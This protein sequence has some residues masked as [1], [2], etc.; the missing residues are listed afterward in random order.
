MSLQKTWLKPSH[1]YGVFMNFLRLEQF[2]CQWLD[3]N[4]ENIKMSSFVFVDDQ[5]L[6]RLGND[7]KITIF[8]FQLTMASIYRNS[9]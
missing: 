2:G 9:V 1:F 3:K 5:K 8:T 6:N 7:L 4:Y